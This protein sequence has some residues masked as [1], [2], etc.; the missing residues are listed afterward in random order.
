MIF[1]VEK[2]ADADQRGRHVA[3]GRGHN[4]SDRSQQDVLK[5]EACFFRRRRG[6]RDTEDLM[7][8]EDGW[9]MLSVREQRGIVAIDRAR[10][11]VTKNIVTVLLWYG[12]AEREWMLV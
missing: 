7:R 12:M 2:A 9:S 11:D 5:G 6:R 1:R 3:E 10:W 8:L 4:D